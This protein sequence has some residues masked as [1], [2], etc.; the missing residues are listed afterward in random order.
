[1]PA[2]DPPL[3]LVVHSCPPSLLLSTTR[4]LPASL[5]SIHEHF[6]RAK[7]AES[8]KAGDSDWPGTFCLY[9]PIGRGLFVCTRLLAGD[10]LLVRAYWPGTFCWRVL[11]ICTR[12]GMRLF[13][14]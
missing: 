1:M 13:E 4:R 5:P 2:F 8:K 10:F 14:C 11:D 3:L 6:Q 9:V 12:P 7:L